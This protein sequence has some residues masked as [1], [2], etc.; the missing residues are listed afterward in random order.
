MKTTPYLPISDTFDF[1]GHFGRKTRKMRKIV[2]A[3]LNKTGS[4]WPILLIFHSKPGLKKFYILSKTEQNRTQITAMRVMH[5]K[6][7]KLPPWRHQIEIY[8]KSDEWTLAY[9]LKTICVK[10]YRNRSSCLGC[11]ADTDTQIDR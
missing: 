6:K 8:P 4:Y 11:R 10:F 2:R 9:V 7:A 3:V 5:T 1:Y